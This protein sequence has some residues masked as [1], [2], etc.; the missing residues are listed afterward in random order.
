MRG[1]AS[2]PSATEL[3]T[4][5]KSASEALTPFLAFLFF[6]AERHKARRQF[7][8]AAVGGGFARSSLG[9]MSGSQFLL[10]MNLP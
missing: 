8:G 3:G 6:R 4:G 5:E 2:G 1:T 9:C 7:R 10:F